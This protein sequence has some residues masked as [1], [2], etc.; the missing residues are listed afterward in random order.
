M[1]NKIQEL[2][3]IIW[4]AIKRFGPIYWIRCHL[5]HR[6]HIINVKGQDGYKGGYSDVTNLIL[7]ASF[8]LLCK[9]VEKECDLKTYGKGNFETYRK[10]Y[11][12][13][14][15]D[16]SQDTFLEG[17]FNDEK[18]IRELYDYWT[19]DRP[20]ER[21]RIDMF[22]DS[23]EMPDLSKPGAINFPEE[24]KMVCQL[25]RDFEDKEQVML[26]K[27]IKYRNYMWT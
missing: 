14:L 8:K 1:K 19:I 5:I 13:D 6:H 12:V 15:T 2:F 7:L 4:R 18:A 25:D 9:F 3:G 21:K 23:I 27:V 26:E 22:Y 10:H 11:L 24:F 17:Q 16:T 20:A